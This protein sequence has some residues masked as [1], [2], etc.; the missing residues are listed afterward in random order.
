MTGASPAACRP[1]HAAN[2]PPQLRQVGF[3]GLICGNRGLKAAE[4]PDS[5]GSWPGSPRRRASQGLLNVVHGLGVEPAGVAPIRIR[6]VSFTVSTRVEADPETCGAC[7]KVSELGGKNPLVVCDDA[8]STSGK[9]IACGLL[10]RRSTLRLAAASCVRRDQEAFLTSSRPRACPETG[11]RRR[12]RL[13]LSSTAANSTPCCRGTARHR[14]R[15]KLVVGGGRAE[16]A[17]LAD[18]FYMQPTS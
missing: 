11:R 8:D 7:E 17:G 2:P 12:L 5:A 15:A 6:V 4:I 1:E 3:S 16:E 14:G 18:G 9:W 13:A 10:E